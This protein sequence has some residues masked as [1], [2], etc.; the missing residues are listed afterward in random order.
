MMIPASGFTMILPITWPPIRGNL[1][2]LTL[3][4]ALSLAMDHGNPTLHLPMIPS[5][6]PPNP[7]P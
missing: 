5:H 1:L 3:G 7:F 4:N 2:A 6:M